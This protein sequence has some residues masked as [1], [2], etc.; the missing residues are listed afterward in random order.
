MSYSPLYAQAIADGTVIILGSQDGGEVHAQ[1][2][3]RGGEPCLFLTAYGPKGGLRGD[4]CL[5]AAEA[6]RLAAFITGGGS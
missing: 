5:L 6:A 4:T 2:G 1:R 3:Q